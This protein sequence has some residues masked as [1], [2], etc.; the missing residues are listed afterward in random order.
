[1]ALSNEHA[2][3]LKSADS[4]RPLGRKSAADQRHVYLSYMSMFYEVSSS[5]TTCLSFI[6]NDTLFTQ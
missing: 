6:R 5:S 1:M 4:Q 2:A 3:P